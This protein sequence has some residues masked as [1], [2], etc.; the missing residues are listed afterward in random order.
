MKGGEGAGNVFIFKDTGCTG[1]QKY[2][3]NYEIKKNSGQH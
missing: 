3:D 1:I 2:C